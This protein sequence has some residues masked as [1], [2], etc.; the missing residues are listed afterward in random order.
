M[1]PK[2]HNQEPTNGLSATKANK[3]DAHVCI[4]GITV[5]D[6]SDTI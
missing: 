2:V 1:G 3:V 5:K 6:Y 4:C